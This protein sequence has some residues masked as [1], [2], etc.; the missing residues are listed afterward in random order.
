MEDDKLYELF[1]DYQPQLSP[2]DAFIKRLEKNMER[3]EMIK[4]HSLA[5]RKRNRIAVGVASAV[6][7]AMG[8]ILTLLFPIISGAISSISLNFNSFA[9]AGIDFNDG[10]ALQMLSWLMIGAVC[11]VTV[12]NAYE[13]TMTK[14]S[15][16][17]SPD[18][19]A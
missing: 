16:R 14:L 3:V 19:K 18:G 13:V 1:Q 9:I 11:V 6:G 10:F 7:F 4:M 8:V 5:M 17:K 12:L 2:D 15:A